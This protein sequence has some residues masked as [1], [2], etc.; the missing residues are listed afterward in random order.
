MSLFQPKLRFT[1]MVSIS[2]RLSSAWRLVYSFILLVVLCGL[3][4]FGKGSSC[5][6]GMRGIVRGG[7]G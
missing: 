4:E 1:F 6:D 7:A 3:W 2:F 5:G